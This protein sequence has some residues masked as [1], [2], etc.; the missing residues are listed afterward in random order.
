M[1]VPIDRL[2]QALIPQLSGQVAGNRSRYLGSHPT[3]SEA[4]TLLPTLDVWRCVEE[5]YPSS[6][7]NSKLHIADAVIQ[8]QKKHNKQPA[9]H[10]KLARKWL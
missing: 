6:R 10:K 4:M 5:Q 2:P 1:I 3:A 7:A 8:K 9:Q